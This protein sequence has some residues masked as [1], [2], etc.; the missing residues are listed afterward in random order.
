M[1]SAG[2]YAEKALAWAAGNGDKSTLIK[3]YMQRGRVGLLTSSYEDGLEY[4][5]KAEEL[6][7][8]SEPVDNEALVRIYSNLGA[9]YERQQELPKSLDYAERAIRILDKDQKEKQVKTTSPLYA[10][11]YNNIANTL[12]KL[13]DTAKAIVYQKKGLSYARAAHDHDRTGSLLNNLGKLLV[14]KKQYAEGYRYLHEGRALRLRIHDDR[15]LASSYRNLALYFEN[16]GR[17]DSTKYYVGQSNDVLSRVGGLLDILSGNYELLANAYEAEGKYDSALMAFR[18]HQVFRDS[19]FSGPKFKELARVEA[20]YE[21]M[22]KTQEEQARQK[23]R[24]FRTIILISALVSGV[25]ILVLLF[26]IQKFRIKNQRLLFEQL[27]L[28]EEKL[29]SEQNSLKTE[30]EYKRKDLAT[31]MLF[32]LKKDEIIQRIVQ[33]LTVAK[34]EFP[35]ESQ[36]RIVKIIRELTGILGRNDSAWQEFELRFKEVHQQFYENLEE[37][38]PDLTPKERRLCALLKLNMTTKEIA[39]IT[40]QSTRSLEV[41]RTRL[42]KKFNLTNSEIGLVDFLAK[43]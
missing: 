11:L 13:Q 42:R 41:A 20:R 43:L 30:L 19:M 1:D 15:G 4:F 12:I 29:M 40:N 26:A 23:A 6:A 22:R 25:I 10:P 36:S 28:R 27:K 33:R 7:L 21:M 24:E 38:Y 35:A 9:I 8:R 5:L 39:A 32:L 17:P 37:R 31:Q 18:T 3:A 34:K 16:T 2:H 14:E